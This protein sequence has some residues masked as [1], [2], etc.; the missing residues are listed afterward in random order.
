[1]R[2]FKHKCDTEVTRWKSI[3]NAFVKS[4]QPA[5]WKAS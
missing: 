3:H 4:K 5:V 2:I 1:L